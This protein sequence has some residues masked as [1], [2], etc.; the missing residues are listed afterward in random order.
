MTEATLEL[1]MR[2]AGPDTGLTTGRTPEP[3]AADGAGS[4]A[5]RLST[6]TRVLRG[7]GAILVVAAASTFMLQRWTEGDNVVRYLTLLALT[8][9]LAGAGI[10]CGLGVKENRGARTLL[11]LVLAMVPVHFTVIGALLRSQFSLDGVVNASAPW[12][13]GSPAVAAILAGA[14]LVSI[15][16][17]GLVAMSVMVR[18]HAAR[19][20]AILLAAHAPILLPIR[21]PMLTAWLVAAMVGLTIVLERRLAGLGYAMRTPEGRFVRALMAVPV[22][23]IAGRAAFWYDPGVFFLGMSTLSASLG[24][25]WLTPQ[26]LREEGQ[27][28]GLQSVF[29]LAAVLGLLL[30]AAETVN[31]WSI[32]A[33][34]A[35][36]VFALPAA[37]LLLMLSVTCAGPGT[38]YRAL[39]TLVAAGVS[40]ANLAVHWDTGSLSVA[41]I[42]CLVVGL[43]SLG[44]GIYYRKRLPTLLG[45]AATAGGFAQLLA[46]AIE[47]EH[48]AHWGSLAGIGVALIFVAAAFERHA[49]RLLGLARALHAEQASWE[50]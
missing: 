13:A 47:V 42:S 8:G 1:T 33:E 4:K 14:G 22:V 50:L 48:L 35:P 3:P 18:P 28:Q 7:L 31:R 44:G 26:V 37:G 41:G 15:A 25:Y 30:V 6:F 32:P 24:L 39:A 12:A 34:I 38:A 27:V 40:G 19:L 49:A 20:T 16:G 5:E 9:G 11:G 29:G 2:A 23:L 10:F 21:D 17:L 45:I 43:G 46:A 36:L